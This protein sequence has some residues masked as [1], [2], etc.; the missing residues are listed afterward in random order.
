MR[1]KEKK[2][3]VLHGKAGPP[4]HLSSILQGEEERETRERER[5]P[6]SKLGEKF[7]FIFILL[8]FYFFFSL[9]RPNLFILFD[10]R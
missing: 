7:Q 10:S 5:F 4:S 2:K 8:F 3:N 1:K 9:S 6:K